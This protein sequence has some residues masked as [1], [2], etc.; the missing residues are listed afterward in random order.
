LLFLLKKDIILTELEEKFKG[1]YITYYPR[2]KR[3]AKEYVMS[4]EEAENIVQDVFLDLWERP[5][6]FSYPV[7]LTAVL[8]VSVKNRCIDFLRHRKVVKKTM[9]ILQD[10]YEKTLKYKLQSL[11]LMD[12]DILSE[13]NLE[14]IIADAIDSLPEKC[15]EIFIKSRIEN[16]KQ[17]DIAAEMNLS[18]NTVESQMAIAYKKLRD[19]LKDLF[20]VIIFF[21]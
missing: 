15:R 4:E 3:F 9:D 21:L 8:I 11:E 7:N 6:C 20:P 16:K 2:L 13:K 14:K 12:Q 17:K 10:E 5:Y 1:I 19:K 18:I